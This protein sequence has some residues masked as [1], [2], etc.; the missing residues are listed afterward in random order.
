MAIVMIIQI[1]SP[2]G[3]TGK[4]TLAVNM[5]VAMAYQGK[6]IMLV[7]SDRQISAS[8]WWAARQRGHADLPKVRCVQKQDEI[9]ATIE[10]LAEHY[11][12][13]VD[14][15]GHDYADCM[16]AA[17]VKANIL[18]CPVRPSELDLNTLPEM[19]KIITQARFINPK[20]IA[21][22]CINSAPTNSRDIDIAPTREI[23]SSY[24]AFKLLDTVI[25]DRRVYRDAMPEGLGVIEIAGKNTARDEI[26]ALMLEVF[27]GA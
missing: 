11:D 4:T 18:I 12:V 26:N 9:G 1:S 15:P 23:I 13:I 22:A 20:L 19:H 24:S 3:G 6:N 14:T 10:D 17:M 25:Y 5:S 2:K 27:G 21:Y 16:R 8:T 7:D